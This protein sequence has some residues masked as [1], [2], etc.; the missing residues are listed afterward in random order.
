MCLHD[1]IRLEKICFAHLMQI[2]IGF[3]TLLVAEKTSLKAIIIIIK[4][5]F[6]SKTRPSKMDE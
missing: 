6:D 4:Y 5:G 2:P 3:E 1:N